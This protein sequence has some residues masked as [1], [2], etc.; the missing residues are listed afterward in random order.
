MAQQD[1][2]LLFLLHTV[3]EMVVMG[4]STSGDNIVRSSCVR[5]RSQDVLLDLILP[6]GNLLESLNLTLNIGELVL[7][8]D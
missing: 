1:S 3:S 8:S 6:T 4:E 2:I 5:G 7:S